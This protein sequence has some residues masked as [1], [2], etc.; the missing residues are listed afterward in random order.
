MDRLVILATILIVSILILQIIIKITSVLLRISLWV[1]TIFLFLYLVN[2]FVFPKIG[3]KPLFIKE[4]ET[5]NQKITNDK[6]VDEV[7]KNI[8]ITLK[9]IKHKKDD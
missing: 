8:N 4:R 9:E 7:Y 6:I 3:L 1:L 2:F 5:L